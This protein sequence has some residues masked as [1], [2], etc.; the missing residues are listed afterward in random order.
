MASCCRLMELN[1]CS[2]L[3]CRLV[4]PQAW[5]SSACWTMCTP[6]HLCRRLQCSISTSNDDAAAAQ[7][8]KKLSCGLTQLLVISLCLE[9]CHSG[10]NGTQLNCVCLRMWPRKPIRVENP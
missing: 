9:A 4:C 3:D 8:Q 6:P 7:L 1:C 5:P 2:S 10:T